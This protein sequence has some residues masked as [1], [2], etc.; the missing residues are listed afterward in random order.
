MSILKCYISQG[1]GEEIYKVYISRKY[2]KLFT[3]SN[4]NIYSF[5]S[6]SL[7]KIAKIELQKKMNGPFDSDMISL[8]ET[9]EENSSF[10][11]I[12][13]I[14]INYLYIFSKNGNFITNIAIPNMDNL[15]STINH[16][17]C[18]TDSEKCIFSISMVDTNKNIKI[19][20]VEYKITDNDISFKKYITINI[21]NSSGVNSINQ[22]NY[23]TCQIM[24]ISSEEKYLTCFYENQSVEIGT[25]YLSIDNLEK[26]TTLSSQFRKNSGAKTLKSILYSNDSKAFVCY[27][28]NNDDCACLSFDII[29]NK[30]GIYEYKYLEGCNFDLPILYLTYLDYPK[31]YFLS[32][33]YTNSNF[34]SLIF[35]SNMEIKNINDNKYCIIEFNSNLCNG[36]PISSIIN[37][38]NKYIINY[39]CSIQNI[40]QI[41]N[42]NLEQQCT[43]EKELISPSSYF[44][45]TTSST[46]K[47][48][49]IEEIINKSDISSEVSDFPSD[50]II[51]SDEITKTHNYLNEKTTILTL[52]DEITDDIVINLSSDIN[53][54]NNNKNQDITVIKKRTT[55]TK[56]ELTNNLDKL[57]KDVEIGKV[58]EIEGEEY[59]VKISPINFKENEGSSTYINFLECENSLRR[60]NNLPPESILTVIQI[61]IY[62]YE[63]KSLTNQVEYAVYNDQKI[64]LDLSVCENDKI[65]I[66]YAIN[67]NSLIDFEK[68]S[69]FSNMDVDIF[70]SKDKFFN[71]I[72]YPYSE[73]NSDMILNDRISD[74]YQN[75]SLCDDNCEYNNMNISSMLITCSCEIKTEI[76]TKKPDLKFNKIYLDLF[77]E[78]SF[79]V[80]KCFKLVFNF[81]NKLNN[82]GFII[83]TIL[84]FLH[85]PFIIIYSVIGVLPIY[86]Y[87][88]NEMDKYK[89]LPKLNSPVKKRKKRYI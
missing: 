78:T 34:Y 71:D 6:S 67:N 57:I 19:Y 68:I 31:E 39:V 69:Y 15:P 75:Y 28:N 30:W 14:V 51:K 41:K 88:I 42:K 70:N 60:E 4:N 50:L 32:C 74:I 38:N 49:I 1:Q 40:E 20:L 48:T 10:Q 84:V 36:E 66:N 18:I 37:Y 33:F 44:P 61:E 72:C 26:I 85:I 7:N 23:V 73:N 55:K 83:F 86:K 3:F 59:E 16:H 17:Y 21:I 62:K 64:K 89:Y 2:N 43:N 63:D 8:S 76:E 27:I 45:I 24:I 52:S 79:G 56:E 29:E 5:D 47:T 87:I 46:I 54:Q 53:I 58:Y 77:T 13:I 35:N 82:I 22:C 80:I 65:E 9:I 81:K 11:I 25:I 12:Y